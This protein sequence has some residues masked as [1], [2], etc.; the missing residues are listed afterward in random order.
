MKSSAFSS[1]VHSQQKIG[2]ADSESV[3]T[4]KFW[5][6]WN[7]DQGHVRFDLSQKKCK[8]ISSLCTFKKTQGYFPHNLHCIS[9]D[10]GSCTFLSKPLAK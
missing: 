9:C 1:A 2:S 3:R 4:S 7:V 5:Q 6:K 10:Y 8:T